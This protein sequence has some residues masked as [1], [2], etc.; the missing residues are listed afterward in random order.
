MWCTIE[1]II[2]IGIVT[3]NGNPPIKSSKIKSVMLV[4]I[5]EKLALNIDLIGLLLTLIKSVLR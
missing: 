3:F 2:D 1:I 5:P 4:I